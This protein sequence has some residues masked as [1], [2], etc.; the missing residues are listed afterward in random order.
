MFCRNCGK[1]IN[2]NASFCIHC[3][4]PARSGNKFCENCGAQPDPL[5]I[6]CVK[7]GCSLK[8]SKSKKK[9]IQ[10]DEPVDSMGGA[11]SSCWRKYAT[12]KGRANR[13]EYWFWVLF[14]FLLNCIPFVNIVAMLVLL[15]PSISVAVRRLH[16]IGKSGWWYLLGLIPLIGSIWLIVLYCMDSEEGDNKYGANPN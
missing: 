10:N 2:E 8:P 9:S 16:D 4:V 13:S 1:E 5:A 3:G 7:C 14:N 12:F 15:I 11:I 6:V